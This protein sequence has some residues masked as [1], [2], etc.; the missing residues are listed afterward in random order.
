[1]ICIYSSDWINQDDNRLKQWKAIKKWKGHKHSS[2]P[3]CSTVQH[4]PG[5]ALLLLSVSQRDLWP[6]SHPDRHSLWQPIP[7]SH[8]FCLCEDWSMKHACISTDNL[9]VNRHMEPSFNYSALTDLAVVLQLCVAVDVFYKHIP[10]RVFGATAG[11]GDRTVVYVP[12][13]C[14]FNSWFCRFLPAC[15]SVPGQSTELWGLCA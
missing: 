11:A 1:M 12:Q 6:Y 4:L 15:L 10:N 3:G 2:E 5:A 13:G 8:S 9:N 7:W 14:W